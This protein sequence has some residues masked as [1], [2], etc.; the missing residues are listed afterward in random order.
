[1]DNT[2]ITAVKTVSQLFKLFYVMQYYVFPTFI[3]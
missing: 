2:N 1:M 3:T